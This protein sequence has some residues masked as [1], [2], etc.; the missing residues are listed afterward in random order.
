MEVQPEFIYATLI[1]PS[2]FAVTMITEGISKILK[3]QS[4]WLSLVIGV[5]FLSIVMGVYFGILR[6]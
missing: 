3:H 1:L 2:L 6:K 4:G 5:V